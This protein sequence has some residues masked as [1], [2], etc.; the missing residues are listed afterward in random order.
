VLAVLAILALVGTIDGEG[1]I[2]RTAAAIALVCAG[3]MFVHLG[4]GYL[5]RRRPLGSLPIEVG[6][7]LAAS[8]LAVWLAA[9]VIEASGGQPR[10]STL[11]S[12][13][14]GVT[15]GWLGGRLVAARQAAARS[16]NASSSWPTGIPSTGSASRG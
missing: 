5:R 12:V 4:G 1:D 3:P 6:R 10:V 13:W 16:R 14:L 11:T 7:L 2:A 9:V 8:G 15:A